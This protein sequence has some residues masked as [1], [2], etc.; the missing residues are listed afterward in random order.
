MCSCFLCVVQLKATK[1]EEA[2]LR[3][4]LKRAESVD[5]ANAHLQTKREVRSAEKDIR[6]VLTR[7]SMA[8]LHD[9]KEKLKEK[10]QEMKDAAK[11]FGQQIAV[12]E[13]ERDGLKQENLEHAANYKRLLVCWR[14]PAWGLWTAL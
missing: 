7:A 13:A 2:L 12:L 3:D 5:A 8:Q 6:N 11:E 9:A 14:T 10:N 4:R 1:A